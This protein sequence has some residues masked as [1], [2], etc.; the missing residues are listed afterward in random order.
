MKL[1][2]LDSG[3]VYVDTN[4][5]YMY[6]NYSGSKFRGSRLPADGRRG[7]GLNR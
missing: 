2:K 6:R 3:S 7:S 4:V 5:L 1:D